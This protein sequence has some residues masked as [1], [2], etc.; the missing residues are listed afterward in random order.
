M[1]NAA[2]FL[3]AL[4]VTR[5]TSH[6]NSKDKKEIK[7]LGYDLDQII[8]NEGSTS[9]N[10]H[11][12][13]FVTE[14]IAKKILCGDVERVLGTLEKLS[15]SIPLLEKE[16]GVVADLGG[17]VGLA[18]IWSARQYPQWYFHVI[19]HATAP[20]ILG[21]KWAKQLNIPNIKFHRRTFE[22]IIQTKNQFE[23]DLVLLDYVLIPGT[24]DQDTD[25]LTKEMQPA[26]VASA[27]LLKDEAH[28][29]I[30]FGHFNDLGMAALIQAAW[31]AGL[32]IVI[33][34]SC[35]ENRGTSIWFK[36][37]TCDQG[38]AYAEAMK[39]LDKFEL[40]NDQ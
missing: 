26:L 23:C 39:L 11:N 33:D 27:T 8:E 16:S 36:K 7:S 13:L 29:L 35:V 24:D 19:D 21:E 14:R 30:R 5:C 6:L 25:P 3:N 38:D 12:A 34:N 40:D 18:S 9:E 20:L 10:L 31:N 22:E 32:Q 17:G 37:T 1:R 28:C 15:E 2:S 4:G